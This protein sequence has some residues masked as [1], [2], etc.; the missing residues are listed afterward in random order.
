MGSF[1]DQTEPL[2]IA[3]LLGQAPT[4]GVPL[5]KFNASVSSSGFPVLSC[6]A[7][8]LAS[9]GYEVLA[10]PPFSSRPNNI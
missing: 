1:L 3:C 8:F 2:L 7:S 9:T 6:S 4:K 5:S 10:F